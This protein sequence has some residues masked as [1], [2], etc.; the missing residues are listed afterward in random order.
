[1]GWKKT[2]VVYGWE[3]TPAVA[4]LLARIDDH[5]DAQEKLRDAQK[6][7]ESIR[8]ALASLSIQ[9]EAEVRARLEDQERKAE[10]ELNARTAELAQMMENLSVSFPR[11]SKQRAL[12]RQTDAFMDLVGMKRGRENSGSPGEKPQRSMSFLGLMIYYMF[13]VQNDAESMNN[14]RLRNLLLPVL[15]HHPVR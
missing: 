4:P 15:H 6:D 1:M 10:K 3:W 13:V 2:N 7:M 11:T 9:T 8:N 14:H 12:E 5:V